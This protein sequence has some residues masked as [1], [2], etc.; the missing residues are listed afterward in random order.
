[1]I[2]RLLRAVLN[3][4]QPDVAADVS[5]YDHVL[6]QRV[7]AARRAEQDDAPYWCRACGK[8]V[9]H[10]QCPLCRGKAWAR[11]DGLGRMHETDPFEARRGG[12]A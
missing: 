3:R 1:M 8:G 12:A 5:E 2:V 6:A 9:H 4:R 11:P 7:A 10:P